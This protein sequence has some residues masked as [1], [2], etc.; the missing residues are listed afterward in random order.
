MRLFISS[1]IYWFI[2]QWIVTLATIHSHLQLELAYERADISLIR[3]DVCMDICLSATRIL[4]EIK[5]RSVVECHPRMAFSDVWYLI[6][7]C[8]GRSPSWIW[9]K[10][11]H[12]SKIIV[13]WGYFYFFKQ[14][15]LWILLKRFHYLKFNTVEKRGS[16]PWCALPTERNLNIPGRN[17]DR[18]AWRGEA[19]WS[20]RC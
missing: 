11:N 3:E 2:A 6:S 20:L 10:W 8:E 9:I 13:F 1:S 4:F 17:W 12:E 16:Q 15:H 19:A 7:D 14:K 5:I 18:G